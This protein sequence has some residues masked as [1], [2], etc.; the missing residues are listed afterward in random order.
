MITIFLENNQR[1]MLNRGRGRGLNRNPLY[2]LCDL[3]IDGKMLLKNSEGQFISS[4][5]ILDK[6]EIT[7]SEK[8]LRI[9]LDDLNMI[10]LID[11]KDNN[12]LVYNKTK[13]EYQMI[14]VIDGQPFESYKTL[15][16]FWKSNK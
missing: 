15:N 7:N 12:F 11:C 16:D 4:Y 3:P 2:P 9:N 5:R 13:K 8:Y 1:L 14:N 10:P 6:D